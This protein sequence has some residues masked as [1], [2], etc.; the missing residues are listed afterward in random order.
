MLRTAALALAVA[1]FVLPRG[2][3]ADEALADLVERVAPS[4][5]NL[6]LSTVDKER[7]HPV[8]GSPRGES[9]GS[10]FVVEDG[11]IITN[12]HVVAN[13]TEILVSDHRGNVFVAELVGA[14]PD[15]DLALLRVVG[16]DLP[17][18]VL[19]SSVGL[20][21]GQD[22]FAVG[23]PFGHGHTVT[24][25]ILSARTRELGR[26]AFDAF[27]QTDAAINQGSSGGPLFDAQGRVI[28][29]NTAVDG[30]GE[31]LGFAMPV[32]LVLGAL[33]WLR[34]GEDVEPGWPGLRLQEVRGGGLQVVTVYKDGPAGRGG[35]RAGDVVVS[36]D[37]STVK[38]RA[39]W[40]EKFGLAFPGEERTLLVTR[41]G[42][43][44]VIKLMLESRAAWADRV[45]GKSVE[46]EG[47]YVTV[48]KIAPDVSER[49]ALSVG[50]Q[51]VAAKRGAI[52]RPGDIVLD[53]DGTKIRSPADMVTACDAALTN[54]AIAAVIYRDGGALRIRHRW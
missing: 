28:G 8:Y 34:N 44:K 38:G 5:V 16:L 32:E 51:V 17:L 4:V 25:G 22:V 45:A 3:S 15:I 48:R 33:P 41:G 21:V 20:R 12:Q 46:I 36:V 50:V 29:V 31:S 1:A 49:L 30:R 47:L 43:E 26:D 14:D 7:W 53:I 35:L 6:H 9:L 42:T 18:V 11:L 52:F 24:R 39:A 54:R 27:L 13:A 37:G 23:N 40:Q 2:A 10:G 19:G